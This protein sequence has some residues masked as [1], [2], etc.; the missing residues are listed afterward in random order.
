MAARTQ[1]AIC[2]GGKGNVHGGH[3]FLSLNTG[4]VVTRY[5]YTILPMPQSVIDRVHVLGEGQPSG[6]SFHD[7]LG[8]NIGD[9]DDNFE[10]VDDQNNITGVYDA[11]DQEYG[12]PDQETDGPTHEF[13]HASESNVIKSEVDDKNNTDSVQVKQVEQTFDNDQENIVP[14]PEE[15]VV[16]QPQVDEQV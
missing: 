15:S 10:S 13:E 14:D 4:R 11:P 12:D 3:F 7:R 5:S 2:L 6:I 16:I 1:G 9:S 8:R